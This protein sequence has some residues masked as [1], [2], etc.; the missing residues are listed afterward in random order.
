M[1]IWDLNMQKECAKSFQRDETL[2]AMNT[3]NQVKLMDELLNIIMNVDI[4]QE[5][6]SKVTLKIIVH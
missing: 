2:R 3:A 4:T 5:E 1:E 6:V